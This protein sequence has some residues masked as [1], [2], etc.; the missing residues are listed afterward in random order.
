M[1]KLRVFK[2]KWF[3]RFAR[4]EGIE[5]SALAE[6]AARADK[7]QIDA[8]LGGGIIKQRIAR[9]GQ[10]KSGGY[11]AVI[12]FRQRDRAV[13]MYGFA[14]SARANIA[15]DEEREFK[16]A[17]KHVLALTEGQLAELVSRGDFVEVRGT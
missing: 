10:G 7:G 9:P 1:G 5:D 14:K 13:F 2:T 17:A 15:P 12:A 3:Q 4:R 6:A 16:E 11:R 8:N